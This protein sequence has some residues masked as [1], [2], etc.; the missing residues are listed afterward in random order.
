MMTQCPFSFFQ[1]VIAAVIAV[2]GFLSIPVRAI[3]NSLIQERME[4]EPAEEMEKIVE[5]ME[6]QRVSADSF[7]REFTEEERRRIKELADNL[8][9]SLSLPLR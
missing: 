3:V 4:K 6:G 1:A 5:D 7:S 9:Q 2:S 8:L